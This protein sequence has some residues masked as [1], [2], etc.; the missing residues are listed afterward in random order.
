MFAPQKNFKM[1][2]PPYCI[3][4]KHQGAQIQVFWQENIHFI[5]ALIINFS[6]AVVCST[7]KG[8]CK[9]F[10]SQK[11]SCVFNV[12][13]QLKLVQHAGQLSGIVL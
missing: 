12:I 10:Q 5:F 1:A 3:R 8:R 13:L 7:I 9:H 4:L 2:M 6:N 11:E